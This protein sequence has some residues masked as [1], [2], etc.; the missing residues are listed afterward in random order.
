MSKHDPHAENVYTKDIFLQDMTSRTTH[1][2]TT[3]FGL[4]R[5]GQTVWNAEKRIQGRGDSPL[6][7]TGMQ[8][9]QE[10]AGYL[11]SREYTRILC[12]DLGRVTQTVAILNK[13]LELPVTFDS[14]LREQ[15][16]G[17]WEGVALKEVRLR[18]ARELEEQVHAGWHFRAPGGESRYEVNSRIRTALESA[19]EQFCGEK[20]LVV[21]HLGVIKC[22]LYSIAGRKFLPNEPK[23]LSKNALHEITVDHHGFHTLNLNLRPA[24]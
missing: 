16:W 19:H 10:W 22:L 15:N 20:V 6:T 9:V 1:H 12:S 11:L 5:H 18:F 2:H 13:V 23:L 14:R 8:Q 24:S 21:C 3:R 17:E 4:L 7:A